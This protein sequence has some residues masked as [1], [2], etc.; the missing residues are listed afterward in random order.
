MTDI[1]KDRTEMPAQPDLAV[2]SVKIPGEA[3]SGATRDMKMSGQVNWPD[4]EVKN[5]GRPRF[6]KAM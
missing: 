6:G 4:L 5:I 1:F 3:L 2:S